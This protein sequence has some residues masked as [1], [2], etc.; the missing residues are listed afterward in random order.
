MEAWLFRFA[1][2]LRD[3]TPGSLYVAAPGVGDGV[4][5]AG[6][7]AERGAS[8]V[9]AESPLAERVGDATLLVVPDVEQALRQWAQRWL[10]D[11]NPRVVMLAGKRRE[12]ALAALVQAALSPRFRVTR[13]ESAWCPGRLAVASALA[14]MDRHA[15]VAVFEAV[16]D[17]RGALAEQIALAFPEVLAID[18]SIALDVDAL[19][20]L[21]GAL[22]GPNP[23]A[24]FPGK[25]GGEGG[26]GGALVVPSGL[27]V[28][29]GLGE[30]SRAVLDCGTEA[31]LLRY[32]AAECTPTG[33]EVRY[34]WRGASAVGRLAVRSPRLLAGCAEAVG[35]GLHLG[36]ELVEAVRGLERYVP[37][38][39]AMRPLSAAS[40]AALIDDTGVAAP[41]D[42]IQDL[43]AVAGWGGYRRRYV[44]LGEL[45]QWNEDAA[46]DLAGAL[47]LRW[48]GLFGLGD[49][50][51]AVARCLR[52]ARRSAQVFHR[53][54]HLE[55][56]LRSTLDPDDLVL[57]VGGAEAGMDAMVLR[58]AGLSGDAGQPAASDSICLGRPDRP[59]WVE[60]DV[61]ALA[62]NTRLIRE[63]AGVPLMAVLKADAYGHGAGRMAEVVLANGADAIA[64][65]CLSEGR[66]LRRAGIGGEILIL[67]YT[68]PW[69][70]REAVQERISC[71]LYDWEMARALDRAGRDEGRRAVVHVKVDTGLSRLG[72]TPEEAP[73]FLE[74]LQRLENLDAR[75]IF[76]H[77]GSADAADLSHAHGQLRRF[78][79]LLTELEAAGLRPPVAHAAN[80]AAALR[81]PEARLDMVRAAIGLYGLSPSPEAPLP[82]GFQPTLTL[83]TAVAQVKWVEPGS[84]VGY[85][86]AY[87]TTALTRVA[88][89]PVGYGDGFRRTPRNWGHVLIDGR[90]CPIL[91]NVCMDQ[92]MVDVTELEGVAP[93]DEV[94]LIGRQGDATITVD[95][96]AANLGTIVYEVVATIMARV[97]RV[98]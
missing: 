98:T 84:R 60:V 3:V 38:P 94:V 27:D 48:D 15:E 95:E 88:V 64:V 31:G 24:P 23:P 80:T 5:R 10:Q 22:R 14:T 65:A 12:P 35:V 55:G 72:L 85:G 33:T 42:A 32:C 87:T 96:V 52:V 40:G 67:G 36:L 77:L 45:P 75:G 51:A 68:P 57:I 82:Y 63:T 13:G 30:R 86:S 47:D 7:A 83:K 79:D 8:V 6:A 9:L 19:A 44:V 62:H 97:P 41:A 61:E 91:G 73:E 56:A 1:Y 20:E 17:A 69:Q 53:A 11:W 50:A 26:W 58:L 21:A 16:A 49:Q 46:A 90:R 81:L 93:G 4:D 37:V 89:L 70:A 18:E 2:R 76:T 74:R 54:A 28:S 71:A 92:T 39:G 66:D 78:R 25:E 34:T 59:T 43:S 29:A